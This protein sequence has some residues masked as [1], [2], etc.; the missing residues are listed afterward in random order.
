MSDIDDYASDRGTGRGRRGHSGS[1]SEEGSDSYDTR[2]RR[3]SDD[4]DEDEDE[5][6]ND[7]ELRRDGFVVD[8]DDIE[9][10]VSDNEGE[11]RRRRKKKKKKK[12]RH[13]QNSER[14]DDDL[15]DEEDLALI[16]ENTNQAYEKTSSRFKRLK[17]G[18]ARQVSDRED[19]GDLQAE[20]DDLADDGPVDARGNYGIDDDDLDEDHLGLFG[21]EGRRQARHEMSDIEDDDDVDDD[22]RM[23]RAGDRGSRR[24]ENDDI[25]VPRR[26]HDELAPEQP[27]RGLFV[28][29]IDQ[30][31]EDTWME[32]QDIFGD[33]EEY[34]FAMEGPRTDRGDEHRE[35]TLSDVFEPAEIAAKMMTERDEAIR[36]AD[37]PERM[38]MRAT[39]TDAVRALSEEEIEQETTW[40]MRHVLAGLLRPRAGAGEDEPFAQADFSNERY[41]AAVYSVLKQL[42]MDLFEVP[43]I[44]RHR[45]ELFVT[46]VGDA[47]DGEDVAT[48]E[49]LT[50]AELWR[51]YDY[52]GLFRGFLASRNATSRLI[53]RLAREGAADVADT[54]YARNQL[55]SA[56]SVEEVGDVAEWLQARYAST[57]H[58]WAQARAA[59]RRRVVKSAGAWEQARRDGLDAFVAAGGISA[60][61][62]GANIAQPGT[63]VPRVDAVLPADVARGLVG[64]HF[65]TADA[66]LRAGRVAMAQVLALDPQIRRFVRAYCREHACVI[67]RATVRGL[68]EIGDEEH[69]AFEFKFLNQKP[70]HAFEGSAQWLALDK[71]AHSGLVRMAFSLTGENLFDPA[72][73]GLDD[74]VFDADVERSA[75]VV[76][77]RLEQHVKADAVHGAAVA[78]EKERCDAVLAAVRDHILPMV[79]RELAQRLATQA[80]D[81]VAETCRRELERRIDVQPPQASRAAAGGYP[82]VAVVAG[83][84]FDASSRGALRV[85][86]VDEIGVMRAE[87][88]ADTM[89]TVRGVEGDGVAPLLEAIRTHAVDV[90]AVAGFNLQTRRL[91]ED[92]NAAILAHGVDVMVTYANDEVARLW[93]DSEAA[94]TEFPSLRREERYCVAVARTM[95]DAPTAYASLGARVLSLDLHPL[96]HDVD[97]A[98][99]LVVVERAFVSVVNKVGVDV[100]AVA[101]HPHLAHTLQYVAGLGPRKAQGLISRIGGSDRALETRS[102]LVMRGLL[103]RTVFINCAS[104][105]RVRPHVDILD[106]TRI[107]PED[108]DLARK[109]ALDALDIE[110]D[111]DAGTSRSRK[112]NDAP[113]RYVAELM[114]R[115]PEKLDELDLVK[116][117]D[118]LNR[119]LGAHKLETLKFIKHEMQHPRD[120]PRMPFAPPSDADILHML[121]GETVGK[122]LKDDGSCVV[123]G[124]IV[125]VQPRFAIARLDSGLEG[126]ISIANVADQ[127]IS[128]VSDELAPG[129]AIVAVVKRIDLEKM[130]M[131]LSTRASDV[132]DAVGR[133][134]KPVPDAHAVDKYFDI[135]AEAAHRE[136][137]RKQQKKT[138]TRSRTI[139]HPLFKSLSSREAERYLA[140]RPRGDCVIRQSSRGPDHI[141]ITWKVADGLFQHIDVVEKGKANAAAL[142]TM[143]VVG[144]STYTD[145]DELVAFHVDPIVRKLDEVRRSPKFYDPESDPLYAAESVESLLGPND[146]SDDYRSRRAAL[147]ETRIARHLDTLA[148]STGRGAYCISLSLAKP[149]SLVLAFKPTP[150]ARGIT[151]WTARVE[152]N[153]FRLGERGRYPDINGLIIGFK[154]MQMNPSA[155]KRDAAGHSS[156]HRDAG[157]ASMRRES[158]YRPSYGT[159]SAGDVGGGAGAG[160][161]SGGGGRWG[162]EADRERDR[163]GG[164]GYGRDWDRGGRG[165]DGDRDRSSRYY[166]RDRDDR[167]RGGRDRGARDYHDRDER[168]R[169]HR[170]RQSR[171]GGGNDDGG[172][173]SGWDVGGGNAGSSH[174]H[175]SGGA[176]ATSSGWNL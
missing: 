126:F 130:S 170:D 129:Q 148:Q 116:Y 113:S 32:L 24:H 29:N 23:R 175:A 127:H 137:V 28:D 154:T 41:L 174:H 100:N 1:D 69:P 4:E 48:R 59:V 85:V 112:R 121:T 125:R 54:D 138:A 65:A 10:E 162:A 16:A 84:G 128:E 50:P 62:V 131:D 145:L 22:R 9:D 78:W 19:E 53:E 26:R 60:Q 114:R 119:I 124:T 30:I 37:I 12:R 123:A 68:N 169:D 34:A 38:Q 161:G 104:F 99:L 111:D 57:I 149:G 173:G 13:H 7:D 155:A 105:L 153:E 67:A 86:I 151:K 71:A 107:H 142:G 89:R 18:R 79:W 166:D 106:E 55:E 147:Y 2:R 20:L 134:R 95:Q 63:H 141:A 133:L 31:D 52:D 35:K 146:Y 47:R 83:G 132:A 75:L 91:Y 64:S 160:S 82:C 115:A 36:R 143:F 39:G 70:V 42:S 92:V 163:D 56:A 140:A 73:P 110:D 3:Y 90:V 5:D 120:D 176:A 15:L 21:N 103:A 136:R 76:A 61:E 81:C 51:L 108:Y 150:T 122:T 49:W 74:A 158:M 77:Q 88:S 11:E 117:A 139:A 14:D 135:E 97:Q 94:Q 80:F 93:C 45:R 172:A 43:Y 27:V 159:A 168:G 6:D 44:A 40:V 164:R 8:D 58:E 17:R 98:A 109:M 144:D 152:P 72:N 118:E 156:S 167:G 171:H 87:F 157:D 66:V 102:D 46:P 165:R 96:Q 101:A 33:G 25:D